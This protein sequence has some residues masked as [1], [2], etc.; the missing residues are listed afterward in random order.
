MCGAKKN[1][2][3]PGLRQYGAFA[4]FVES[5]PEW[6]M[7]V[8]RKRSSHPGQAFHATKCLVNTH[9]R[10]GSG[11]GTNP[12]SNPE[13][14]PC[15]SSSNRCFSMAHC[16]RSKLCCCCCSSYCWIIRRFDCHSFASRCRFRFSNC[17]RMSCFSSRIRVIHRAGCESTTAKATLFIR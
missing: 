8:S 15:N 14:G 6:L 13:S 12:D 1:K 7:C 4:Q 10:C 17:G 16:S 11:S 5:R 9:L 2:I 3:I